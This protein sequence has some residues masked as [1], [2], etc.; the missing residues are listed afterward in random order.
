MSFID[1][2]TVENFRN[3]AS[4]YLADRGY[5]LTDIV[6]GSD[7]WIIAHHVGFTAVCYRDRSCKDSHIATALKKVFPNAV[8]TGKYQYN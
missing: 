4:D 6:A 3:Q 2:E 7:A 8:L 5:N 1:K